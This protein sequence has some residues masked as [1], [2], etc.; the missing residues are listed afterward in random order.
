MSQNLKKTDYIILTSNR[1]YGSIMT[2]PEK[3]PVTFRYYQALFNGTLGFDKVAEFTSRPN[4][5]LPFVKLC[6]TPP[7]I[8][9]GIIARK[10]QEC[11]LPGISFVTDYADESFTVYDHP[12]VIIFKKVKPLNYFQL[13]YK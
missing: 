12:K 10:N 8:R 11:P 7:F 3:Y 2:V 5:P 1:L 9:Y 6:L 4:L 13:L